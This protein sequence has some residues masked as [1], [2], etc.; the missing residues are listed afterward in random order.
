MLDQAESQY[1]N[2]HFHIPPWHP[3][4][5]FMKA[6]TISTKPSS[7]A[8]EKLKKKISC[9]FQLNKKPVTFDAVRVEEDTLCEKSCQTFSQKMKC[10]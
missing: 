3:Q 8:S 9:H 4:E 6:Y 2:L 10:L 1:R 7:S 5:G